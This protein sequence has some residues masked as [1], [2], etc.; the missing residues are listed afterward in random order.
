MPRVPDGLTIRPFQ[1]KNSRCAGTAD[2]IPDNGKARRF[3]QTHCASGPKHKPIT[4]PTS[5]PQSCHYGLPATTG[6]ALMAR[7]PSGNIAALS[8]SKVDHHVGELMLSSG[9]AG[10]LTCAEPLIENSDPA[11]LIGDKA[12]DADAFIETLADR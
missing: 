5:E 2:H 10:D 1:N 7:P 9:Q 6:T 11:A 4:L 8:K 3:I 12:Y